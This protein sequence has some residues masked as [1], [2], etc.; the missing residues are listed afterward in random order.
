MHLLRPGERPVTAAD[1]RPRQAGL[2]KASVRAWL[3]DYAP[4]MGA[5]LSYYTL[6]SLAP[7]L[8]IVISVAGLVFG[9]EAAR[10]EIVS[11][12]EGM[13]GADGARAA[14][15]LLQS[16]SAP[17][18]GVIATIVGFLTLLIGATSVFG[19]LQSDLDRIWKASAAK[20]HS[21]IVALVRTRLLSFGM[22]LAIGFLLLVS[23]V[24]S[25]ALAALGRLW[26]PAFADRELTLQAI[27]LATS[28]V[29]FSI[30]FAIIYK[31]LPRVQVGW[32]DVWVGTAF[33]AALFIAGKFAIGLYLGKA[34][35]ASTFGAASS[36]VVL[37]VWVYYSAQ[38]FLLGA[39]FTWLFAHK[40]GSR[41]GEPI[42]ELL[43]KSRNGVG[44]GAQGSM[45]S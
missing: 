3:E 16:A 32:R 44:A 41:K 35:L 34:G 43:R 45:G 22:I 19:E 42:P 1:V 13:V 26:G 14:Q 2:L 4:S 39:E 29:V 11:Q 40:Y 12:L 25:A 21:G 15:D 27:S 24:I 7:M 20:E 36:L 17:A 33:T 5:A 9:A 10:G 28:F 6:F 23:L 31:I 37:M 8:L 30:L 38:I 18:A